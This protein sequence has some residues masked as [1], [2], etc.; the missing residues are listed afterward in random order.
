MAGDS[1]LH[2]DPNRAC[3]GF[4][5]DLNL[6]VGEG[7]VAVRWELLAED[8]AV[9]DD[10]VRNRF[11]NLLRRLQLVVP[12]NGLAGLRRRNVHLKVDPK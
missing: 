7:D 1:L 5:R 11:G 2:G 6:D 12:K 3:H 10:N 9:L 8:G 4:V